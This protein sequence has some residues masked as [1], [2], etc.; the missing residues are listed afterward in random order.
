MRESGERAGT[1]HLVDLPRGYHAPTGGQAWHDHVRTGDELPSGRRVIGLCQVDEMALWGPVVWSEQIRSVSPATRQ[2][3]PTRD[4][5][6][7]QANE[8][9][10][11]WTDLH[12][13]APS[14]S[15]GKAVA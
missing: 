14:A 8:H 11:T 13:A 2:H 6:T 4:D 9:R 15:S 5:M 7:P 3:C 12:R 1:R 10:T